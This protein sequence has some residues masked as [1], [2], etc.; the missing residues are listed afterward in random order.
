MIF[1]WTF[2][3]IPDS[4]LRSHHDQKIIS[5]SPSIINKQYLRVFKVMNKCC[6]YQVDL[7]KR[8]NLEDGFG[9]T[10]C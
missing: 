4:Q 9:L 2:I 5:D 1:Q 7:V 3:I 10:G 8:G 6:D